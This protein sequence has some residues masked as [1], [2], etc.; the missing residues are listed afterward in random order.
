MR[1]DQAFQ[2][3]ERQQKIALSRSDTDK[4]DQI[5]EDLTVLRGAKGDTVYGIYRHAQARSDRHEWWTSGDCIGDLSKWGA[6]AG[7]AVGLGVGLLTSA[8]PLLSVAIG[9]G[10]GAVA[11][12]FTAG[13]VS[14]QVM[15]MSDPGAP[16]KDSVERCSALLAAELRNP[17]AGLPEIPRQEVLAHLQETHLDHS[18]HGRLRQAFET[19]EATEYLQRNSSVGLSELHSWAIENKN[20]ATAEALHQLLES[21]V[22]EEELKTAL[23]STLDP[24]SVDWL[25]DEILIGDSSLPVG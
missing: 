12:L 1:R 22:S 9:A 7:T 16:I 20:K 14:T 19:E 23:V 25:E 24:E 18:D 15:W 2:A 8:H 5:G 6:V 10:G 3:L 21:R 4:A 11:G 13:M 17:T